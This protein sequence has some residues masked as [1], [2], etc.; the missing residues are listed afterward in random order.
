MSCREFF[1]IGDL[2][3]CRVAELMSDDDIHLVP[4]DPRWPEMFRAEADRL[5]KLLGDDVF[6]RVEHVG[7][8]AVP[9]MS[10]KPVIDMLVEVPSFEL[11]RQVVLPKL[12]APE[13][14]YFWRD[15]RPPGHMMFIHR[16]SAGV[17]THHVHMA[18]A[19]HALW[20][21]IAFRDYLCAHPEEARRYEQLK[22]RLAAEHRGDREA[23]TDGKAE[24]VGRVTA[25]ALA[26]DGKPPRAGNS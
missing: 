13:W 11:A 8:T 12:T 25:M 5:R 19:G 1:Q 7:S 21:R 23:Y 4:Y 22:H 26:R 16:D 15:D 3:Q 24:Y 20:E 2:F 6:L 14:D 10:A 9:G 18:P 17:R